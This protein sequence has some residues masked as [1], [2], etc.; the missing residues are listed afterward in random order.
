MS[1]PPV[2]PHPNSPQ[3]F[4]TYVLY[5]GQSTK[6]TKDSQFNKE[7]CTTLP[8]LCQEQIS[9][10]LF[11]FNKQNLTKQTEHLKK[12]I[13][14]TADT[15]QENIEIG[16]SGYFSE[17]DSQKLLSPQKPNSILTPTESIFNMQKCQKYTYNETNG[18][19]A[20]EPPS[21]LENEINVSFY[22]NDHDIY[23][24]SS[25]EKNSIIE[26]KQTKKHNENDNLFFAD[27]ISLQK[28]AHLS[29][30]L[31]NDSTVTGTNS[32]EIIKDFDLLQNIK[33][34][35]GN[36]ISRNIGDNSCF[37]SDIS[38]VFQK[39]K[40]EKEHKKSQNL[41]T[42]TICAQNSIS[43]NTD[44]DN[45][46][47]ISDH[48]S[49]GQSFNRNTCKTEKPEFIQNTNSSIQNIQ[50]KEISNSS[51][52]PEY[53]FNKQQ[54][55]LKSENLQQLANSDT[56]D[57][58]IHLSRPIKKEITSTVPHSLHTSLSNI[59]NSASTR[60]QFSQ[61]LEK[62]L[63]SGPPKITGFTHFHSSNN[64]KNES[65]SPT[66]RNTEP[67][68]QPSILHD[69]R[70]TRPKGPSR[71]KPTIITTELPERLEFSNII[72]LFDIRKINLDS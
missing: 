5:S 66:L 2:P 27:S 31:N 67:L 38:N 39:S 62:K 49:Y 15:T 40:E 70:K 37:S 19:L 26:N 68:S 7:K 6:Q 1:L 55:T 52:N 72:Q 28:G 29:N 45:E 54:K 46:K 35:S 42:A 18:M 13:N 17:P 24:S 23:Q 21:K 50:S 34:S 12:N 25:I 36:I 65:N 9:D 48:I 59:K 58:S 16:L 43:S 20:E 10:P 60:I 56:N 71:H 53:T 14:T 3:K 4:M 64:E 69:L 30:F 47:N 57:K 11:N 8:S 22:L 33:S 32:P 41:K 51:Q 63:K 44:L 61:D